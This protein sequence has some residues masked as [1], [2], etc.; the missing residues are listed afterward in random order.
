MTLREMLAEIE[1]RLIEEA[2]AQTSWNR[3]KAAALLGISRRV[4]FD[5]IQLYHLRP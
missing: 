5:K 1:R 3:S 2:L 4:L